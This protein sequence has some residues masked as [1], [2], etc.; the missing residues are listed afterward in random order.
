MIGLIEPKFG[1]MMSYEAYMQ[2]LLKEEEQQKL[3]QQQKKASKFQFKTKS[4]LLDEEAE[5]DEDREV[6]IESGVNSGAESVDGDDGDDDFRQVNN[7]PNEHAGTGSSCHR[8]HKNRVKSPSAD[9]ELEE[10]A[11][12]R[13]IPI[14]NQVQSLRPSFGNTFGLH[15]YRFVQLLN[16]FYACYIHS[17]TWWDT[18]KRSPACPSSHPA[19][20]WSRDRWTSS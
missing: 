10:V 5:E 18:A 7:D 8:P 15:F 9:T 16:D 14:A 1:N 13:K 6:A 17:L 2:K 20:V 3:G 12:A 4:T 11:T 19:I